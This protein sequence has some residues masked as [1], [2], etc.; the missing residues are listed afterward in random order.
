MGL[1]DILRGKRELKQPA[2]D[3][4]FAM[5]TAYIKLDMEL[6]HRADRR[7]FVH[8]VRTEAYHLFE[9]AIGKVRIVPPGSFLW[10]KLVGV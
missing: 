10:L 8:D 2:A 1:F 6:M 9:A 5:S 3:R 4:L 7:Q